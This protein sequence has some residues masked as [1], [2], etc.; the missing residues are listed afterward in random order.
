MFNVFVNKNLQMTCLCSTL[1]F[2]QHHLIIRTVCCDTQVNRIRFLPVSAPYP[3][4]AY[5]IV[6]NQEITLLDLAAAK[7][8]ITTRFLYCPDKNVIN[9]MRMEY[10]LCAH[11]EALLFFNKNAADPNQC[12]FMFAVLGA[13]L[14]PGVTTVFVSRDRI[15]ADYGE[16]QCFMM[17][18]PEL[19]SEH[20]FI[21]LSFIDWNLR[22]G[23][24]TTYR[25]PPSK[26]DM[27]PPLEFTPE[28]RELNDIQPHVTGCDLEESAGQLP[29]SQHKFAGYRPAT[30]ESEPDP[31]P[32]SHPSQGSPG[33][34]TS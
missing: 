16:I 1:P 14:A 33:G 26:D 6:A 2:E 17:T 29:A 11:M 22:S 19:M 7:M 9:R 15:V 28:Y 3:W 24:W 27:I 34:Q 18:M 5:Y 21:N 31:A 30:A 20:S 4:L 32:S 25:R 13:H 12:T 8:A 23:C 10:S